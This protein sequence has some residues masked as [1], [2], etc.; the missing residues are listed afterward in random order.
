MSSSGQSQRGQTGRSLEESTAYEKEDIAENFEEHTAQ[1]TERLDE[2]LISAVKKRSA[3]YNFHI[4]VK[5]RG[6]KQKTAYGQ[7]SAYV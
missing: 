4:L 6:K 5:E 3:L 1:D 7:K 2:D